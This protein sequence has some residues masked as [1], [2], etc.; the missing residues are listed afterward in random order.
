MV[1]NYLFIVVCALCFS[2]CTKENSTDSALYFKS[3]SPKVDTRSSNMEEDL[4]YDT[5][6]WCTGNDII[7]Y[8]ATTGE[9][10]LK[11]FSELPHELFKLIVFLDEKQLFS[12]EVSNRISSTS[13]NFPCINWDEGKLRVHKYKGEPYIPMPG[14]YHV[15]NDSDC[16]YVE[17]VYDNPGYYISK[18]Y[19]RWEDNPKT[20]NIYPNFVED[21]TFLDAEREKNWKTIEPEYNLFIEQ[22]KKEGKYRE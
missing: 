2:S 18:G 9:L 16:E 12:L 22:L 14:E 3:V 4:K 20:R 17:L 21:R 1:K 13:T 8:N 15:C 11:Y 5:L 19:P 7:W 6:V 10:K